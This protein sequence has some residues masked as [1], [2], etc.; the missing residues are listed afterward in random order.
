MQNYKK[1]KK[2]NK[3]QQQKAPVK[4]EEEIKAEEI[5][6]AAMYKPD[7][8]E[9]D[10]VSFIYQEFDDMISVRNGGYTQF[11][12]MTLLEFIENSRLRVQGYVPSAEE[13]G[14]EDWQANVFN[15][16]TRNKLKAFVAA[17]ASTPPQTPIRARNTKTGMY[18]EARSEYMENLVN[19]ARSHSN[20]EV[21]IFWEAWQGAT[22]GTI[23][24]YNGYLKSTQKRKFIKSYNFATGE[25][26]FDEKEVVVNDECVDA[27]VPLRELFIKNIYIHDIQ[28]QPAIV[29]A[30]SVDRATAEL[31]FGRYP[32]W[33][34]VHGKNS[35][36]ISNEMS[37]LF[38]ERVDDEEYEILKYYNKAKDQYSVVINGVLVLD[39]P[40]LWG[41]YKKYY[42]FAK[43]ICEPF[44]GREFFYGNSIPNANMDVQD[45]INKLY[46]MSLDKT[47][48]S[49]S[50]QRLI[51]NVNKDLLEMENEEMG[52]DKDVYVADVAQVKWQEAPGIN[53][54]EMAMIK[55]VGQQF[56][57]GIVDSTQQGVS[58]KGVTAR[59]IVI[60]NENAKKIK[61]MFFV[62][63]ADL[64]LQKTR[65]T[66]LNILM[67]YPVAKLQDV[68]GA[69]GAKLVQETYPTYYV[70]NSKFP[71]GQA[72][73]LAIQIVKDK[74]SLPTK[75]QLDIEEEL[76]KLKGMSYTKV[77]I[78]KDYFADYEY[79][80][81]VV[82]DTL[83]QQDLAEMQATFQ[84]KLR[85]MMLAFP[86][87]YQQNIKVLF[88]DFLKAYKDKEGKYNLEPLPQAPVVPAT[89]VGSGQPVGMKTG[90]ATASPIANP[91]L[92]GSVK[93]G[94][95]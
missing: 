52:M 32:N 77:A 87:I 53:N 42:P 61:G 73:T 9:K 24:K 26:T 50:P 8:T 45:T 70:R 23:I 67:H 44:N 59:E 62:F 64:W 6:I 56:D 30:R 36:Y 2:Q 43:S 35:E 33:K 25:M 86:D 41:L 94:G 38:R 13:Q 58:G 75:N 74:A 39:T 63:L 11:N 72:G 82:T 68:L 48:R 93:V 3:Q 27:F 5:K 76:M 65:L 60:A 22:E 49:L 34:Y 88:Q 83:Y 89:S 78:T 29:W 90:Q 4:T 15:Q 81:E 19:Y 1:E 12:N 85:I 37:D 54:S 91:A 69:E 20:P 80:P 18:D 51:G 66:V 95:G 16:G 46:N 47:Y 28:A 79:E 84:D 57:L 10:K 92:T 14:K 17:V 71:N 7:D 55:W 31:E 40:L 21:E